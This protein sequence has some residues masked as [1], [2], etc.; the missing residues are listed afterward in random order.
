MCEVL[1]NSAGLYKLK[2]K[3]LGGRVS[4]RKIGVRVT[5]KNMARWRNEAVIKLERAVAVNQKKLVEDQNGLLLIENLKQEADIQIIDQFQRDL[6]CDAKEVQ[7]Q[8]AGK[9]TASFN[10]KKFSRKNWGLQR[11]TT[12]FNHKILWA[13]KN[14]I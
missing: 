2:F 8:I 11:F 14:N 7:I 6:Q 4:F 5:A 3:L 13:K 12:L 10:G 9:L 1:Q